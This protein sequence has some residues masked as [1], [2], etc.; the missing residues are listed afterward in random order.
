MPALARLAQVA[1]IALCCE[2]TPEDRLC[3]MVK[4]LNLPMGAPTLPLLSTPHDDEPTL[5]RPKFSARA[6][7]RRP[8]IVVVPRQVSRAVALSDSVN[9]LWHAD[10]VF[11]LSSSHSL[12]VSLSSLTNTLSRPRSRHP[13]N[14]LKSPARSRQLVCR[15]AKKVN[16][17]QLRKPCLSLQLPLCKPLKKTTHAMTRYVLTF[18]H[19]LLLTIQLFSIFAA[20]IPS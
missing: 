3:I 9:D 13:L 4:S 5:K 20:S 15:H 1:I 14:P 18:D 11:L 17:R 7:P 12:S 2:N 8:P 16:E 10:L 19:T 6:Q